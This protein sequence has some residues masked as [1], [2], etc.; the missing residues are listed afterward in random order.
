T[1]DTTLASDL[2]EKKR[3]YAALGIPEYWVVD[4]KGERVLA[5]RL[6]ENGKYQECE[7]SGAL[8]GL[9]IALLSDTLKLLGEGNGTA[10]MWF[11]QQIGKL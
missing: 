4:I 7:I 5:F 8:E 10:A 2:D 6:Q 1:S 3:L 11:A 9:P